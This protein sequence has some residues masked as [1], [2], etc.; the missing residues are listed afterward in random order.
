M[1]GERKYLDAV[2]GRRVLFKFLPLL[3]GGGA[4][5][6]GSFSGNRDN[7]FAHA[8]QVCHHLLVRESKHADTV[9]REECIALMVTLTCTRINEMRLAINLD[10]ESDA[11]GIKIDDGIAIPDFRPPFVTRK[12]H[13]QPRRFPP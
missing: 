5:G 2:A 7:S 3:L 11:R 13:S 8:V 12:S 10:G 1:E 4:G 6:G 9:T